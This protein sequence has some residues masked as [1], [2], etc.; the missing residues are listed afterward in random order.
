MAV[1]TYLPNNLQRVY[2]F[3]MMLYGSWKYVESH[4]KVCSTFCCVV[5]ISFT[6]S[7]LTQ[8]MGGELKY[9]AGGS[10]NV[11]KSNVSIP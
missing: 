2:E 7:G 5:V 6:F 1:V 3:N 10:D 9:G 4:Q 11:Q 8:E